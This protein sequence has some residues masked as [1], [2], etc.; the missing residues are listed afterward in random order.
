MCFDPVRCRAW[1]ILLGIVAVTGCATPEHSPQIAYREAQSERRLEVPPDLVQPR[2]ATAMAVPGADTGGVLPDFAGVQMVRAGN[3]EWLELEG[4]EPDALWPRMEAFLRTQG[5]TVERRAPELGIIESGWAERQEAPQRGGLAGILDGLLGGRGGTVEDRY[6][7]RLERMPEN[8]GTRVF[9]T[10]WMARE[11]R[12]EVGGQAQVTRYFMQRS[13]GD[14]AVRA[15]MNRRLLVHLG[16]SEEAARSMLADGAVREAFTAAVHYREEEGDAVV[17]QGDL[18]RTWTRAADGLER[19]G[20]ELTEIDRAGARY[21]GQWVPPGRE[22]RSG[23]LGIGRRDA[24]VHGFELRLEQHSD[25]VHLRV[26][27]SDLDEAADRQ[28]LR[29][30]VAALGGDVDVDLFDEREAVGDGERQSTPAAPKG[31]RGY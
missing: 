20:V 4:A 22:G 28:L 1:L 9:L 13:A 5:L 17:P 23:F 10:H 25:A 12:D 3:V 7:I 27:D 30:L 16:M 8:A 2:S 6:Q 29:H 26:A 21:R 11:E 18:D 19:I 31:Q 14:P 15:E 24:E